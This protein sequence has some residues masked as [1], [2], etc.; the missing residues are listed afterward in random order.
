MYS[1]SF[2]KILIVP[3]Y[4]RFFPLLLVKWSPSLASFNNLLSVILLPPISLP[5][6][7][8]SIHKVRQHQSVF[9]KCQSKSYCSL[10]ST[11][12]PL[13]LV[14]ASL[15]F[16][17][18]SPAPRPPSL[19]LAGPPPGRTP[20]RTPAEEFLLYRILRFYYIG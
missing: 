17:S 14:R 20:K 7:N 11:R 12:G 18:C 1:T 16:P 6:S 2:Y 5:F 3:P 10:L 13:L 19:L 9:P 15:P 4:T 8:L